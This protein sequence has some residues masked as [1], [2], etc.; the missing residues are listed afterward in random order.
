MDFALLQTFTTNFFD[1]PSKRSTKSTAATADSVNFTNWCPTFPNKKSEHKFGV[2][3][4][5]EEYQL[6]SVCFKR[7]ET[8]ANGLKSQIQFFIGKFHLALNIINTLK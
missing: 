5:Q 7:G 4:H 8:A 2:I 1:E 3:N 6:Y